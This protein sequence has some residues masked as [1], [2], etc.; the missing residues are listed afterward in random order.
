MPQDN[1]IHRSMTRLDTHHECKL[2]EIQAALLREGI[3]MDRQNIILRALDRGATSYS[4][5]IDDAHRAMM[6]QRRITR[7]TCGVDR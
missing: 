1:P 7:T 6:Q 2:G 3:R 4:L 5:A